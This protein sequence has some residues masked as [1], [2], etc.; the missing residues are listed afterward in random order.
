MEENANPNVLPQDVYLNI[1]TLIDSLKS[2]LLCILENDDRD[3]KVLQNVDVAVITANNLKNKVEECNKKQ[4]D[5]ENELLYSRTSN[6]FYPIS[7]DTEESSINDTHNSYYE[8]EEMDDEN[9]YDKFSINARKK[10]LS[11]ISKKLIKEKY[12]VAELRNKF[13][14]QQVLYCFSSLNH[15]EETRINRIN[16][17]N[18]ILFHPTRDLN[19]SE[20]S[21]H[22]YYLERWYLEML[23]TP[24]PNDLGS[25]TN[26]QLFNECIYYNINYRIDDK[27]TE[28]SFSTRKNGRV[29]HIL[30]YLSN[31]LSPKYEIISDIYINQLDVKLKHYLFN[32]KSIVEFLQS[33]W[34]Q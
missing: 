17:L 7:M 30:I 22:Q 10:L 24:S 15:T 29:N 1:F 6:S 9:E 26:E 21:M 32:H 23:N 25:N 34:Q 28:L 12:Q 2:Q 11:N 13:I 16:Y 20:I 18:E 14:P 31:L 3:V 33:I 4:R 8:N 5:L 19:L 27:R